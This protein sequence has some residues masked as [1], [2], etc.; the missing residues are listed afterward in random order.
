MIDLISYIELIKAPLFQKGP[1]VLFLWE[2]KAGWPVK[3]VS[4]NI[5]TLYGY[6]SSLYTSNILAYANQI[7]PDDVPRVFAEVQEAS[8]SDADSFDHK[9]YRYKDAYGAFH[10]VHDS[11]RILRDDKGDILYYMGY[12]SDITKLVDAQDL[13][14]EKEHRYQELFEIAPVGIALNRMDGTFSELNTTLY[15]MCGYTQKEFLELSYWDITP[16]KYEPQEGEQLK[17]L[18]ATGKYGPYAKEYIHKDGHLF[19]V[20]L[21]GIISKDRFGKSF[22]WSIV[23][24]MTEHAKVNEEMEQNR[25]KFQS[26]FK[27][28]ND[29]IFLIREGIFS[30]CNPKFY[31]LIGYDEDAFIAKSPSDISPQYQ[32][33]GRASDEKALEMITSVVRG[34][35]HI[36]EWQHQRKDGSLIDVEVSLALFGE[37][38]DIIIGSWRDISERKRVDKDLRDL[39][40]NLIKAKDEAEYANRAKGNFLAN[41]SHE[42]RTPMNAILGFVDILSKGETDSKREIQFDHIRRSGQSLLTIINDTLDFS[43]IE[44]GKLTIEKYTFRAKEPFE[45]AVFIYGESATSNNIQLEYVYDDKLPDQVTGD[46]VRLKQVVFNL[47]S[48]AIKFTQEHGRV[49]ITVAYDEDKA[50]LS[51]SVTDTGKGISAKNLSKIFKAFEQEDESTTREFGGTGLGLAIS[52]SLVKMMGG[53]LTV[54]STLHMGSCFSF[55]IPLEVAT[56]TMQEQVDEVLP[57][58]FEGKILVVEDNKT[59]Q[60]LLKIYL[61]EMGLSFDMANDGLEA[62]EAF[63]NS[64]YDLILMDENMPNMNG[65]QA[66]HQIQAIEKEKG[67]NPT[68]IVAVTANALHGD[69][70]R[71]LEAG[72]IDYISKPFDDKDLKRTFKTYL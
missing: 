59:N 13:L 43:K 38:N 50:L 72:M 62:V 61:L 65:I 56:E 37:G 51:C 31:E 18:E 42:I 32:P 2:N 15:E 17:S 49:N 16:Q 35:A 24:D 12:I 54:E 19:P 39:N 48:N 10:W 63:K 11:T 28:S 47:L 68:P 34:E 36:F 9:P 40:E 4:E 53:E 20:L 27:S 58:S 71:F 70:E 52:S 69:K 25:Q 22:I 1:V 30:E 57:T 5:K 26:L 14:K 66:T 41:V 21:N 33:D 67:L 6:D 44:S 29:A 8:E 46:M 45:N 55:T 3:A 60:A 7:H 23:Q 64:S